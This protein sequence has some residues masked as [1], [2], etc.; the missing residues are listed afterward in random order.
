[1]LLLVINRLF[2]AC[3]INASTIFT[4]KEPN[5]MDSELNQKLNLNTSKKIFKKN[6]SKCFYLLK[7]S[8]VTRDIKFYNKKPTTKISNLSEFGN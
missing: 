3:N 8:K 4:Q 7:L 6:R 1:M 2:Y 5:N